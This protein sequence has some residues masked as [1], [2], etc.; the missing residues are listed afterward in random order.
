MKDDLFGEV[1]SMYTREQAIEDRVLI[2]VTETAKEAGFRCSVV[3]TAGVWAMIE[4]IPQ[5]FEHEDV[6]GRLWDVLFMAHIA[7]KKSSG[8]CQMTY[9]LIL[10]TTPDDKSDQVRELKLVSG[11][12]DHGE[13][14]ITIML[15]LE[16]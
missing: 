5:D 14:V 9:S 11:P 10:H 1:I 7:I 6:S 3:L 16:D 8:G 4:S 13:L 15:P 2:D 12:G